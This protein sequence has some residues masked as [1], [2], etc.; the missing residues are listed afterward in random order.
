MS[1]VLALR[2]TPSVY[3]FSKAGLRAPYYQVGKLFVKLTALHHIKKKKNCNLKPPMKP[4]K[5]IH[6]LGKLNGNVEIRIRI[7]IWN[8]LS[9]YRTGACQNL[10]EVL[11]KCN[12]SIAALQEIRWTD[13]R[14]IR[15]G[16]YIIYKGDN[17][18]GSI[19]NKHTFPNGKQ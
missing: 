9:L 2:G 16:E 15:I 4:W 17:T 7:T 1:Y 14:Q 11:K 5:R 13:T 18:H 8:I 19:R 6:D 12:A 10:T 3:G